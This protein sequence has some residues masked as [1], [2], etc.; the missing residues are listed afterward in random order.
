MATN[1]GFRIIGPVFGQ[2]LYINLPRAFAAYC[3][4]DVR[5]GVGREAYLSAF[6]FGDTFVELLKRTGSTRGYHGPCGAHWLWFDIDRD[7]TTGG[8]DAALK[9]ARALSIHLD[10][11]FG[12]GDDALLCFFS[13]SKGFHVG[14]PLSGF[15]PPPGLEFHRV[16]RRFAENT[17]GAVATGGV[18]I[19]TGIYDRVRAFRAPNSRHPRTGRHKRRLTVD[20]L[21]H[22]NAERIVKLSAEPEPFDIADLGDGHCGAE[23]PA[24]WD[25]AAKQVRIENE[26]KA[27]RRTAIADGDTLASVNRGTLDFICNGASEGDRHRLLF[28]SA[29]NLAECGAPLHLCNEL[30]RKAA[31]NSRL[32]PAAVERQIRC[33]F[34]HVIFK[35]EKGGDA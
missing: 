3:A 35:G 21:L 20:E 19:D 14:L 23:L 22:L 9:D 11:Q 4:A 10:D 6:M 2:R 15:A 34:E 17:A 32:S 18:V 13:G 5:G 31:L 1:I 30:L 8:L 25:A 33:G 28:S 27:E 24:A 26:A 12:V 16:A 7:E 29:A